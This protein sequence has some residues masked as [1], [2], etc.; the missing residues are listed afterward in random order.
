M[1]RSA[2]GESYCYVNN[3]FVLMG[4][5]IEKARLLPLTLVHGCRLMLC[6]Q[7]SLDES[8]SVQ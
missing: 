1:C 7:S 3:N 2:P 4:Y 6:Q 5:F 8:L